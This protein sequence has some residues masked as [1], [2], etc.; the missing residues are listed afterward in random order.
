VKKRNKF[1]LRWAALLLLPQRHGQPCRL[2][3]YG[4]DAL[5]VEFEDGFKTVTG[6]GTL[7]RRRICIR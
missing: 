2:L 4:G 3:R 1:D 7:R 5:L 6:P